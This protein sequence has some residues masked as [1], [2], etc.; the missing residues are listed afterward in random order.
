V[1]QQHTL[2]A[3]R[4]QP[5]NQQLALLPSV[6][7]QARDWIVENHDGF[8]ETRVSTQPSDEECERKRPLVCFAQGASEAMI[9]RKIGA[10]TE[11]DLPIPDPQAEFR[12]RFA[13]TA[14][15][16]RLQLLDCEFG[17]KRL[18]HLVYFALIF[19]ERRLHK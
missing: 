14:H 19:R 2:A 17:A 3:F 12:P 8:T 13:G 6:A 15:I 10:R 18:Q 9:T 7:V 1:R 4:G 5:R 16:A 11:L